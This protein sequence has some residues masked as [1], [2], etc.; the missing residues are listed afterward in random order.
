MSSVIVALHCLLLLCCTLLVLIAVVV[1][2]LRPLEQ[3][4]QQFRQ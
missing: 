3:R 1:I 4:A 2:V